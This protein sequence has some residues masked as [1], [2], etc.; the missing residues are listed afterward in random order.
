MADQQ[1]TRCLLYKSLKNVVNTRYQ[2][3]ILN[4]F[5]SYEEHGAS[6]KAA[7]PGGFQYWEATV[8]GVQNCI[9][10][11]GE[12]SSSFAG[13]YDKMMGFRAYC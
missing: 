3:F 2:R 8:D 9:E 5:Q 6:G 10:L 7:L 13:D 1:R 11:S 12:H 4:C